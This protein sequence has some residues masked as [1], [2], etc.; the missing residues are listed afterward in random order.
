MGWSLKKIIIRILIILCIGIALFGTGYGI[1]FHNSDKQW[2]DNYN[3]FRIAAEAELSGAR[4][5][6]TELERAI[7]EYGINFSWFWLYRNC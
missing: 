5:T 2:T 1:G 4:N 3:Q 7:T 6:I